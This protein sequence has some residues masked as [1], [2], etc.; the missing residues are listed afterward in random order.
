MKRHL[1]RTYRVLL[2]LALI[3]A[4]LI[5]SLRMG[6]PQLS[7][8][9]D[10]IANQLSQSLGMQ[11]QIGEL[12]ASMDQWRVRVQLSELTLLS[13][14]ESQPRISLK[15]QDLNLTLDLF[16][17]ILHRLP[18]FS[19]ASLQHTDIL[20][21]QHQGRWFPE[22]DTEA[23]EQDSITKLLALLQYQPSIMLQDLHL[24]LQPEEGPMQLISP[25]N[26]MFEAAAGEYQISGS[27]RIPRIG[28]DAYVVMSLHAQEFDPQD[29][30]AGHYRFYVQSDALGAELLSLGLLPFE[31]NELHLSTHLWGE[32]KAHQLS[33]LQGDIA[34]TPLLL[35]GERW[36]DID[37]LKMKFVLLPIEEQLYQLQLRDISAKTQDVVLAIPELISDFRFEQG[38]QPQ[39]DLIQ[40]ASLDL[41]ALYHWVD[42][43]DILPESVEGILDRLAPSGRLNDLVVYWENAEDLSD[44]IL[45][46]RLDDV[47]VSAW[48]D[49]PAA[50]GISGWVHAGP[51]EGQVM[52][53][54]AAFTLNFPQLFG[55]GWR[56]SEASGQVSWQVTGEALRLNSGILSLGNNDIQAKGRF[57]LYRPFDREEQIEF[58]LL[59]GITDTDAMQTEFYTPPKELGQTLY[60]WLKSSIKAGKVNQAGL[61]IHAGLRPGSYALPPSVQ[62][63][64]DAD[65][66]E[67]TFDNNWPTVREG[68]VF[69]Q[70]RNTELRIDIASAKILNST[71]QSG[72]IYL[73]PNSQ[74]VQVSAMLEGDASDFSVLLS[75][76]ALGGFLGSAFDDWQLAGPTATRLSLQ[77]PV[78]NP[79]RVG[80]QVHTQLQG[81]QLHLQQRDL[82]FSDIRGGIIYTTQ[83][84][85]RSEALQGRLFNEALNAT[86]STQGDRTQVAVNGPVATV[87]LDH[88]TGVSLGQRLQGKSHADMTLT[89]CPQSLQCPRIEVRSDLVG[90]TVDLPLNLG[91]TDAEVRRLYVD[92]F[93]ELQRLHFSYDQFLQGAFDLSVPL[94]GQLL[95]GQGK[96]LLPQGSYLE[97]F[98]DLPEVSV[99]GRIRRDGEV[100]VSHLNHLHWRGIESE[101]EEELLNQEYSSVDISGFPQ[102]SL[103]ID[104]LR[105][106]SMG[107]GAWSL[108]LKPSGQNLTIESIR[109][110]LEDFTLSGHAHWNA[111]DFPST[112][113]TA[114]LA[115]GDLSQIL[116]RWDLG[117]PIETKQFR[118]DAQLTW[119]GAPWQFRLGS[120]D[121]M[122][123]FQADE[124]RIIESG[125]GANLL[126]VFGLLNL[127]TLSRRLRLD[128]SDLLQKGLVFD[129]IKADYELNQGV[130]LIREPLQMTGPSA[131]MEI[132]GQV[133][134]NT[135]QLDKTIR[136]SMPIGSN[137]TIG[138]ALLGAPHVAGALFLFDRVMGDRIDK[139]TR[140]AYT[141]TGDWKDPQLN[142]LNPADR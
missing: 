25:I 4:V 133:S 71:V 45:Q 66:A 73:P 118:S 8:Y 32:W 119:R 58:S 94:R 135:H 78:D 14:D 111:A 139:M 61:M 87:N 80:V 77:I 117:R 82:Q 17:T 40:I 31:M 132:T 106:K 3:P 64:L 98:G 63:F 86:I 52:L 72:W 29:P 88:L 127:N 13:Q 89:L 93:P 90:T 48:Q 99:N 5:L 105:Y 59:I 10:Q 70:L 62:L 85:L 28:E 108:D 53:E 67:F 97:L 101:A 79:D 60:D 15:A 22:V 12:H 136:V 7:R 35:A 23:T 18:V 27:V 103:Q 21:Q 95:L 9:S 96:A 91:K 11:V 114:N 57:G 26:A 55:T 129:Q 84:G 68:R 49:V 107:L 76:S 34:I 81:N 39:L 46:A 69:L 51:T 125:A 20:L 6:L 122:F 137:L 37:E 131:N 50:S 24:G 43:L 47:A 112:N 110:R 109:G 36:P 138:A 141:L 92:L 128:F 54:S 75:E 142:L 56:Y 140:I 44:F 38:Q 113:L 65:Q 124:G 102:V 74:E 116:H 16:K 83:D 42:Q 33:E 121:G 1:A 115:G 2:I 126:R 30:L 41:A 100:W 130:A 123:Q 120:L 104:D 19:T 134:L